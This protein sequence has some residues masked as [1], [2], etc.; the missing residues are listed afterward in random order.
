MIDFESRRNSGRGGPKDVGR[1]EY[2]KFIN[3]INAV[4]SRSVS[5]KYELGLKLIEFWNNGIYYWGIDYKNLYKFFKNTNSV[6]NMHPNNFFAVCEY[7]FGLEKSVVSRL[8]NVVDEFGNGPD[9]IKPEYAKFKYSVLCEML[10]LSPEER[11]A[12]LP[13]WTVSQVR[14]YKKS[15]V[16]TSQQEDEETSSK[17]KPAEK[18]PQF[19][20]WKRDDLCERILSLEDENK[21]L[22]EQL[23]SLKTSNKPNNKSKGSSNGKG[24]KKK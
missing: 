1:I 2:E 20:D 23:Q 18:Y 10:S 19:K 4:V 12:V 14:E 15:L 24:K 16:A 13:E 11:K 21:K 9:G 3:E 7:E 5:E 8:M 6:S 22:L 17:E